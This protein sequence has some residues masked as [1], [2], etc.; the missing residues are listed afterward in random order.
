MKGQA[1]RL[2]RLL[3]VFYWKPDEWIFVC[4]WNT[5]EINLKLRNFVGKKE[6][7]E[8]APFWAKPD[9]LVKCSYSL[10]NLINPILTTFMKDES[11]KSRWSAISIIQTALLQASSNNTHYPSFVPCFPLIFTHKHANKQT[12]EIYE[13]RTH[14]AV[15]CG[16]RCN[17]VNSEAKVIYVTWCWHTNTLVWYNNRDTSPH[18]YIHLP[19]V[20]YFDLL[21]QHPNKHTHTFVCCLSLVW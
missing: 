15:M 14:G 6:I 2:S 3:S 17:I 5:W 20:E 16:C 8:F 13:T 18:I 19:K 1:R 21:H 7:N 4:R 12:S 9:I 10:W 11:S